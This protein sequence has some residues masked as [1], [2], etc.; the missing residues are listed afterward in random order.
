MYLSPFKRKK[1]KPDRLELVKNNALKRI[2]TF[3]KHFSKKNKDDN[4]IQFFHVV[5]L[6]FAELF[7][8]KYEFT[9][10]ELS[11][12]LERRRMDKNLKEKII[13]FLKKLSVVEYSD[14][15][16]PDLELRKLLNEFLK[17]FEKLTSNEEKV[18]ETRLGKVLR[19]LKIK[20]PIIKKKEAEKKQPVSSKRQEKTAGSHI[21]FFVGLKKVF[22]IIF[23]IVPRK[24]RLEQVHDMLIKALDMLD[25]NKIQKSKKL[26]VKIKEKYNQLDI[27][28]KK[29]V[30]DDILLLYTEIVSVK[31][32]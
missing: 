3:R 19:F 8:I 27:E 32:D 30:Y 15:R 10:E 4:F 20:R 1:K 12:E 28:D 24:S 11:N 7:R 14:E 5:R 16:L 22:S 31:R 29:D 17:L 13:F 26:Y 23:K 18:K 2:G 9:F 6:F 21:N 25:N